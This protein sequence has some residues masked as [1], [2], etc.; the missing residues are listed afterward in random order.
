WNLKHMGFRLDTKRSADGVKWGEAGARAG[1]GSRIPYVVDRLPEITEVEPN[2]DEDR[3]QRVRPPCIVNGRVGAPG[4][5]DLFGFTGRPGDEVVVEVIGRRLRSPLDSVI[6]LVDAAGKTLA[7]NDDLDE[8][9]TGLQTHQADSRLQARLEG[10]GPW[11]VRITDVRGHGGDDYAYRLRIGPPQP[12]FRVYLTPSSVNLRAGAA[13]VLYA[14]V[15]RTD[16]FD[17]PVDIALTDR[18]A[19]FRLGGSRIPAGCSTVPVTLSAPRSAP[20]LPVRLSFEAV[21]RTNGHR[22]RVPV[23]PAEDRMQ[24]FL[25]RHLMP[26]QEMLVSVTGRGRAAPP[27]EL[28]S[29]GPVRLRP[30]STALVRVHTPKRAVPRGIELEL[31]DS[32][33]GVSI[34]DWSVTPSGLAVVLRVEREVADPPPAGNLVIEAFVRRPKKTKKGSRSPAG[35]RVSAGVLPAVPFEFETR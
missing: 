2:G 16:G 7:W 15:V 11:I 19:G 24:A 1:G 31:R 5:V 35:A 12:G 17:G 27:A 9:W 8:R 23:T 26:S 32:P 22:V 14:H 21:G 30:G 18:G 4:D 29:R 13:A 25:N 10:H 20:D 34:E 3:L 28:A 6:H 33:A